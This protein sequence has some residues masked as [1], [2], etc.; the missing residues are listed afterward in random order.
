MT[1]AAVSEMTWQSDLF[2][3]ASTATPIRPV[4]PGPV[5]LLSPRAAFQEVLWQRAALVDIR[6]SRQRAAAGEPAVSLAPR[7]LEDAGP[8]GEPGQSVIVLCQDGSASPA[9]AES[10]AR[11][12]VRRVATVVGGFASWQA[13]GLPVRD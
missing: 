10:L 7:P 12:G 9:V 13:L 5:Q 8:Q 1:T 4:A 6:P 2:V 11:Q 3:A